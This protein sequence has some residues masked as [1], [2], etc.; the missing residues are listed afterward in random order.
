MKE[1]KVIIFMVEGPS[2]EDALVVPLENELVSKKIR[3][4]TKVLHTDILTKYSDGEKFETTT[5]NVVSKVKMIIEDFFNKSK[6]L[7][8]KYKD[9]GKI[10]Y[11]TDTDNCFFKDERHSKNKKE[12]LKV[13]FSTKS[14]FLG[15]R[16][17]E[18][19]ISFDVIFMSQNLEHVIKGELRD[20]TDE[21][22]RKIS[23][24]FSN[25]CYDDFTL[26][27]ELFNSE[28]VK[29][30]EDYSSSYTGIEITEERT[31]NMNC[32]LSEL[33]L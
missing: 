32:L 31:S 17:A 16:N 15:K 13:L 22:K 33:E 26:Y 3:V 12:C 9:I 21:E 24:V 10:I 7:N 18:K 20:Y 2:D 14:I 29:K 27:T 4:K 19:E 25:A 11:V 5:S 30:W 28:D 1:N 8:L 23:K 6:Y